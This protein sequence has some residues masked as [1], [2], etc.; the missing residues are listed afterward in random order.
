MYETID[1]TGE[2]PGATITLNR[3]DRLNAITGQMIKE[4]HER[5]L[6]SQPELKYISQIDQIW[7][8]FW[9]SKTLTFK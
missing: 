7:G 9:E 6:T 1:Y 3:P 8:V 4:I 2:G 5:K